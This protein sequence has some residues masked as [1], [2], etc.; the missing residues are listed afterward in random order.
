MKTRSAQT[1]QT[2]AQALTRLLILPRWGGRADS[3]WYASLARG[4]RKTNRFQ[5]VRF[6]GIPNPDLPIISECTAALRTALGSDQARADTIVVAHSVGAQVVL[7][8]LAD[9]DAGHLRGVLAVAGWFTVDDLRPTSRPWAQPIPN[10]AGAV[11][12]CGQLV[13]LVSDNEPM[14]RDW[15]ANAWEWAEAGAHVK[16]VAGGGHFMQPEQPE[17]L[18]ALLKM[19]DGNVDSQALPN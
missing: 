6:V 1:T 15:W 11:A 4:A 17:V 7:R 10:L 19:L 18:E 3:D 9:D 5:E 12:A 8:T 14:I 2:A 16:I 13:N